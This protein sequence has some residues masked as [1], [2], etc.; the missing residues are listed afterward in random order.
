M[1]SDGSSSDGR[2]SLYVISAPSG[3]GKTTLIRRLVAWAAEERLELGY[4][5]SHTNRPPRP[6]ETPGVSYHFVDEEIFRRMI[7]G[8]EF[9][10]WAEVYGDLKGTSLLEI[11][12]RLERG[13]DVVLDIDV[14]GARQVR[15]RAAERGLEAVTVFVLPPG[16]DELRE[17]IVSR[18][19]DDEEQIE[20]RLRTAE[21]E[22]REAPLYDYVI[23]NDRLDS[24][25]D[26]LKAVIL[27]RRSRRER[28]GSTIDAVLRTFLPR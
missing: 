11:E 20:T 21:A 13:L 1:S 7:E 23:V 17:R 24:A 9:L 18:G 10:E 25:L 4:S 2:G 15:E 16:R 22:I 27:A 19:E 6:S 8:G 26:R 14:Q 5:V 3:A 28:M 12:G